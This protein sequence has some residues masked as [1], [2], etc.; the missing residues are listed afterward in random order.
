M[1]GREKRGR[2]GLTN[3]KEKCMIPEYKENRLL[4]LAMELQDIAQ[5][6]IYYTAGKFDKERYHQVRE[7][8]ARIIGECTGQP[9][10][11]VKL[12]FCNDIGYVTPKLDTRAAIFQD[13][14]ILLVK[15]SSGSWSMPGGWVDADMSILENTVKEVRE[16]A[17]LT[18]TA[19]RLIAL[20]D[21]DKNNLKYHPFKVIK[22][23]V[24]CTVIGGHFH[25]NIETVDSAYFG[26]DEL[27]ELT[28]DKN[29]PDQVA[30]CF[31]AMEAEKW[32][33]VFD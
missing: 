12:N 16:E 18:V 19:D 30:L 29:T 21:L 2:T 17:G 13:G 4:E 24:L 6:G 22:A 31:K 32:E 23:F 7:I 27:P 3:D 11:S 9:V 33:T 5:T 1:P 26:P 8:A 25:K 10:E 14:K 28:M 15:E 20:Q